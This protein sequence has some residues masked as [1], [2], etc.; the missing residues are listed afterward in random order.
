MRLLEPD[1][2]A[3]P[4]GNEYRQVILNDETDIKRGKKQKNIQHLESNVSLHCLS[5]T[6]GLCSIFSYSAPFFL[7]PPL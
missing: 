6:L 1:S 7:P 4:Q 5:A 3:F 2:N